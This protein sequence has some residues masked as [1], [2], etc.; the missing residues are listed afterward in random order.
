M[1]IINKFFNKTKEKVKEI[2]KPVTTTLYH[3]DLE[4]KTVDGEK[5]K[6]TNMCYGDPSTLVHKDLVR[7][8]LIGADYLED[9]EGT[10]YPMSNIISITPIETGK[11]DNVKVK[12]GDWSYT[13]Y[14]KKDIK[15]YEEKE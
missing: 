13:W 5:H 4:F 14:Q 6:F 11:I 15:I 12:G 3:Y 8:Y 7:Y 10:K 1:K 9:D 2:K